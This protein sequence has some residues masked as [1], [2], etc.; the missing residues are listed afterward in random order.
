M[1]RIVPGI[2]S[3]E[4]H[5][6]QLH[7]DPEAYRPTCCPHCG[8]AV[9]HRHGSYERN[10]PRGKGLAFS[11]A[12]LLVPRFYCPACRSTCSRLPTCLSPRRHYD[13]ACQQAVL[14]L[15]FAG[16]SMSEVS[17]RLWPS[18]HTLN[19]WYRRLTQSF[20]EHALHLRNRFPD[21]G[22]HEG[23]GAFWGACFAQ[24]PLA[25]A[26]TWLDQQGVLIP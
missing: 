1:N 10:T 18:R 4:Q 2:D 26:M 17:R 6:Q 20:A 19:R 25:E 14:S 24:M 15:L 11:L 22:R 5:V 8:K 9:L 16:A 23:F 7:Q 21:L 13:W 12:R 3:L